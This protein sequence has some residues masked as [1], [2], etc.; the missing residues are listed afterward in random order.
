MCRT[1]RALRGSVASVSFS[2]QEETESKELF[3]LG[4]FQALV[5]SCFENL[6]NFHQELAMGNQVEDSSQVRVRV[7]R[8]PLSPP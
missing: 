3:V 7:N 8:R 6:G 1:E 2:L 4:L 5:L